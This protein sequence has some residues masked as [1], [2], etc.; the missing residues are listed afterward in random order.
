MLRMNHQVI[1]RKLQAGDIPAYRI[2]REWR[3]EREQFL[4]WLEGHS[5]RKRD[6]ADAW[7]DGE[8]RLTALPAKPS[9]RRPVLERLAA[10]FEPGRTYRESDVNA[11]LRRFHE[12]VAGLRREM[13]GEK[14]FVRS[15]GGVYKR[16]GSSGRSAVPTA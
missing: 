1:Q 10:E 4:A 13:V 15:P 5:N 6:A 3:V 2:G 14:L 7:F 8:G 16:G 9:L 11:I 12:D